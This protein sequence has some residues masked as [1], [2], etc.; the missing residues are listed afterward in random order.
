M[1]EFPP[2]PVLLAAATMRMLTERKELS[3]EQKERRERERVEREAI[4]K[5]EQEQRDREEMERA[6]RAYRRR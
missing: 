4:A 1:R 6:P 5:A 3:P 2:V